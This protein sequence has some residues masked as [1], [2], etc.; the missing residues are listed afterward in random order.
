MQ[1]P[2]TASW[3]LPISNHDFSIL[4]AGFQLRDQD[5]KYAFTTTSNSNYCFTVSVCRGGDDLYLLILRPRADGQG[6]AVIETIT[7]EPAY[8]DIILDEEQAKLEML[9][10]LKIFMQCDIEAVPEPTGEI[11]GARRG[12]TMPTAE[13]Q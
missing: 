4:R 12:I 11:W 5:D 10:L 1:N 8:G 2:Q 9:L 3:G 7:W 13:L 6:G